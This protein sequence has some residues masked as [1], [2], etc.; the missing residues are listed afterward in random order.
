VLAT[1]MQIS[2]AY[3]YASIGE[4][5]ALSLRTKMAAR[6]LNGQSGVGRAVVHALLQGESLPGETGVLDFIDHQVNQTTGTISLRGRFD[7]KDLHLVP[8]FY[9]KLVIEVGSDRD[10]LVLPRAVILNDQEGDHVFVL[11]ADKLAH[12]RNLTTAALPNEETEVLTGL[13]GGDPVIVAGGNK[14]SDGQP[15]QVLEPSRTH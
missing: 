7:N 14:L 5:D 4:R 15:V 3:V 10:A 2:P 8:G 1:V 6:G 13:N 9:A 11:G 12:R